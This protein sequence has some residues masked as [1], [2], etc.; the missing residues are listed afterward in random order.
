VEAWQRE[1]WRFYDTIGELRFAANWL[2]NALS[3]AVLTVQKDGV[4]QSQG[5]AVDAINS[6]FGGATGQSQMLSAFAILL[7]IPGEGY[8]V[9]ETV[10]D[11]DVWE[12]LAA[13]EIQR[14]GDDGWQI[15]RGDGKK[16]DL[17]NDA[18]VVRLWRS[19]P[20]R[21]AE[22]DSP[23]RACIPILSEIENLSKHVAAV[24]DSR[25]AG[26][27]ILLLPSEMSFNSPANDEEGQVD[28]NGDA[29]F[30]TLT[31]AMVTPI[32]DRESAAAVVPI[33]IRAPGAV[34]SNAQHLKFSTP[35]DEQTQALRS[36][37]IRRL[38]LGM[39]LP[40]EILLGTAGV[41]H[42]GAWQVDEAAIKMHVEP[43]LEL[44]VDAL[45]RWF[46]YPILDGAGVET[47]GWRIGYDT[48][49]LRLRPNRATQALEL[50]DRLELN[51]EALRRETGFEE[52]DR[53][54]AVELKAIL[55]KKIAIGV[56]TSDLTV[57]AL[58][59]LGLPLIPLQSQIEVDGVLPRGPQPD[60]N[61]Q[62]VVAEETKRVVPVAAGLDPS[63]LMACELLVM[64]AL[65]RATNR[66]SKRGRDRSALSNGQCDD[67]LADAWHAV[68]RVAAAIGVDADWLAGRLDNYTRLLLTSAAEHDPDL[69]AFAVSPQPLQQVSA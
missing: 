55:L 60:P 62:P 63:S 28:T 59:D 19:H 1:V 54:N 40:P 35:F 47:S 38:A 22:A 11:E 51:S 23:S 13:D 25:L 31:E 53:P 10:E 58:H 33:V 41:N 8:L 61:E 57:A 5:V 14:K 65:E 2:G 17:D 16:R 68:P 42:W 66:I 45:T 37:A 7:T 56:S 36:E 48:S 43:L 26:A 29:F 15:D 34:L 30:A 9:G 39:D 18:L 27:G 50:Y 6:L 46:L 4:L 44:I 3:R 64:R 24:T 12:V 49:D 52:G 67:V 69:L 21:W 32:Q 20:R